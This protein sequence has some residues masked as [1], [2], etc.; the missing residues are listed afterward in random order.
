[1]EKHSVNLLIKKKEQSPLFVK[2]NIIFPAAAAFSLFLFI[3]LFLVSL[4]YINDNNKQFS[5]LKNQVESLGKQISD[6]K[7]IEGIYT[8]TAERVK[9][10]DQL[11]S[12]RKNYSNLLSKI[13]KLQ[14]NGISI[15]SASIDKKN[16]V[17]V[18][19][20]ASSAAALDEFFSLLT[21]IGQNKQFNDIK[22]SGIIRDRSG[23]YLLSISFKPS[24]IILK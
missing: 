3:S 1:M 8:L 16:A 4:I 14:S 11:N 10:I 19:A 24:E 2:L 12:G 9:I 5:S 22:S 7:N 20:V 6:K 21:E 23:G 15:T 13:L 18:S 17:N